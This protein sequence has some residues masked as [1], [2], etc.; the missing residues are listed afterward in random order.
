MK[1]IPDFVEEEIDQGEQYMRS[2]NVVV[3]SESDT[4]K[5]RSE[6]AVVAGLDVQ[7]IIGGVLRA[8]R[9]R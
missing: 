7:T 5:K 9:S 6:R 1:A 3:V 4:Q 2:W 8:N